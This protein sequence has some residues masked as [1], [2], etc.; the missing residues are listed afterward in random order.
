MI[1]FEII[2]LIIGI[3]LLFQLIKFIYGK[4]PKKWKPILTS[5][6]D[7]YRSFWLPIKGKGK[8]IFDTGQKSKNHNNRVEQTEKKSRLSEKP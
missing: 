3:F 4:D 2:L 7:T 6:D 5:K 1:Y 8:N